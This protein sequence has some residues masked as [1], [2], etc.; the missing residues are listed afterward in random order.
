MKTIFCIFK[1]FVEKEIGIIAVAAVVA[2]VGSR[3]LPPTPGIENSIALVG[4]I[5]AVAG[6]AIAVVLESLKTKFLV[7]VIVSSLVVGVAGI[8]G[9]FSV[10][11]SIPGLITSY[12]LHLCAVF[13]FGSIGFLLQVA[14]LK[15]SR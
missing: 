6:V 3:F 11:S 13:L 1:S 15:I 12:L 5:S 4:A 8:F 2:T 9:F 14:K 7:L 10:A